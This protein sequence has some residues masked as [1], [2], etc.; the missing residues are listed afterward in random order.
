MITKEIFQLDNRDNFNA[1]KGG[2]EASLRN[3]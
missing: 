1:D 3:D 2:T